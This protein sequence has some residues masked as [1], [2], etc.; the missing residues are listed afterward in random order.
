MTFSPKHSSCSKQTNSGAAMRSLAGLP[1]S[2]PAT[3]G[4]PRAMPGGRLFRAH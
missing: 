3:T 2:L 4:V 1:L